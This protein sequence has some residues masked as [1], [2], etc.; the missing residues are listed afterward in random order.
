MSW[1][2]VP[3]G[4]GFCEVAWRGIYNKNGTRVLFNTRE[5]CGKVA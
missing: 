5:E 4:D 2:Q 3:I 1:G